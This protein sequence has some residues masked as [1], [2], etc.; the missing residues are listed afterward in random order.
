[1]IGIISDTHD[2]VQNIMNA[3]EVFKK[4][5]VKLV[6]HLGDIVAPAT[7]I[8]F[9]DLP[10]KFVKG[11]VD[12]AEIDIL[13][14]KIEDIGGEFYPDKLELDLNGKKLLAVHKPDNYAITSGIYDYYLHGHTHKRRN[15]KIGRTRI[16][17]PGSHYYDGDNTIVILD[18]DKNKVEF[19][20][21]S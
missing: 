8:Y 20:E 6:I 9:K 16:I 10:M 21:V 17:N 18:I 13:Q 12:G 5:K 2:N 7:V 1:M 19:I 14:E 3:V 4:L 11:N 15:Q